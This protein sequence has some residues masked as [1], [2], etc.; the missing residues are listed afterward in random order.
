[1][2]AFATGLARRQSLTY[3]FCMTILPACNICGS[4]RFAEY[5]GRPAERCEQ[6]GSKARH[7]VGLDVYERHLFPLAG[8]G[9]RVLHFAPEAFLHSILAGKF[10]AGY[11][12]ADIAPHRYKHAKALRIAL[13]DGLEVFPDGYFDAVVHNHVL[14][15]IPG[16]WRDHVTALMRVVK[17]GGLMIFSVPGPYMAHATREG[18]ENL[19]TD[20]ERLEQFLQEDHFKLFG[21]DFV[22]GLGKMAGVELVPDG[23]TDQRRAQLC[24]RPGKA[25]FFIL[26]KHA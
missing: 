21:H 1:M 18:G 17:P 16:H 2:F 15:H 8:P 9:V 24:V 23:V 3:G 12:T 13:P 11:V 7:R 22:E 4:T 6:C 19:A 5:R 25:P 20:A 26:G 14:E 10:G